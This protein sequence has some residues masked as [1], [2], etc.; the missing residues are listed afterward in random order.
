MELRISLE[1]P[2]QPEIIAL[3]QDG[4]QYS[5]SLYPAESNH[6][7]PLDALRAV[8]VRFLV[9]RDSTGR[10]IATGAV[11]LFGSGAESWAE[12]KRMWVVPDARGKGV[13]KTVLEALEARASEAGV[14]CL[15]LETGIENHAALALYERAGFARRDPFGDYLPD[16]LSVFMEKQLAAATA[17][18]T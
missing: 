3:L 10:A 8:H 11:A 5:A 12:L 9:A 16:P 1:D 7:L 17:A 4:E 15:R 6:H 14:R 2:A 13:S 18:G